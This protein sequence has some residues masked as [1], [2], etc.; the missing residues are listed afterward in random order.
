M[1]ILAIDPSLTS[2]GY[3]YGGIGSRAAVGT[4]VPRKMTGLFRLAY[5]RAEVEKLITLAWPDLVAYEGYAMS[6]FA[7]RAFDLGELG[8][9]LKSTVYAYRIPL[10][11]VPPSCLKLYATGRG[12][13]DKPMV[14]AEMAKR[15][16]RLFASDDEA[17]AYA[18]WL[19]GGEVLD[20][21]SRVRDPRHF[22]NVA[23]QGCSIVDVCDN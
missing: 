16:G 18:L 19:M 3:A 12:N 11:I 21:R 5:L 23:L 4:I 15:R 14:M 6:R 8:G 20:R 2:T 9:V 1:N 7:N 17:D 13:A 22:R 10:L